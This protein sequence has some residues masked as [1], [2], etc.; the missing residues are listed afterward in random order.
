MEWFAENFRL[1]ITNPDLSWRLRPKFYR[2]LEAAKLRPLPSSDWE[3]VLRDEHSAPPRIVEQTR[4]K[5]AEP[6]S[7]APEPELNLS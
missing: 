2:A 5:I 7:A 6:K 1:F 4:K 3:V